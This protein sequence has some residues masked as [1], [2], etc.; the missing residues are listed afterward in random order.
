M[1][2]NKFSPNLLSDLISILFGIF[3]NSKV[4]V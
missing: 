4:L 3:I 1:K 2:F